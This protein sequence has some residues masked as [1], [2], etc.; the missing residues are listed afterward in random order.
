MLD[1]LSGQ[2]WLRPT[3]DVLRLLVF[4]GFVALG[5]SAW[6]SAE[7][8]A[9]DRLL[10]YTLGVSLVVGLSQVEAWPFTNWALVHSLAPA[11]LSSWEIEGIDA[12]GRVWPVDA[13]ILQPLAPEE[14]GAWMFARV[15]QLP[16]EGQARLGRFLLERA[17]AGR[18]RLRAGRPVGTNE[19][20][21][22]PLAA[23]FHFQQKRV[24]SSAADVPETPFAA[25]EVRILEWDI[26]ERRRD[27]ARVKRRA[28]LRYPPG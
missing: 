19:V 1:T 25:V 12:F 8:R 28:F 4:S 14:F 5:I 22:G 3:L 26:E 10:V 13:R 17:E 20:V 2:P 23:P 15:P 6:R 24:W 7:R 18:L 11:R 9:V 21:L 16:T 27:D